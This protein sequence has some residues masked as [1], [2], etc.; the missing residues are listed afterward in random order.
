MMTNSKTTKT[1]KQPDYA[2]IILVAAA[3]IILSALMANQPFVHVFA[4]NDTQA[5]TTTSSFTS[6]EWQSSDISITLNCSDNVGCSETYYCIDDE[7][8]CVPDT[9]YSGTIIHQDEGN[10]YIRFYST[11]L[12]L[13]IEDTKSQVLKLDKSAPSITIS[14]PTEGQQISGTFFV[15]NGA[16][17]DGTAGVKEV[18]INIGTLQGT[19]TG[20]TNWQ[21]QWG[22]FPDGSYTIIA[23]AMDYAGN[24]QNTSVHVIVGNP[25]TA[26]VISLENPPMVRNGRIEVIL[27]TS[28]PIQTIPG[29]SPL[30]SYAFP[31][32]GSIQI[33]LDGASQTWR[34]YM[35][36]S[37]SDHDKIGTFAFSATDFSGTQGNT[38]T[39]GSFFVVDAVKPRKIENFNA[40]TDKNQATLTWFYEGEPLKEYNLYRA[41][42]SNV[43]YANYYKTIPSDSTE[44]GDDLGGKTY[45][46]KIA[47]VDLAGNIGPLSD[48][49]SVSPGAG[50]SSNQSQS[51]PPVQQPAPQSNPQPQ[52]LPIEVIRLIDTAVE[53]IKSQIG[54]IDIA[55]VI[56]ERTSA[57]ED[58][59][60]M[61][62]INNAKATLTEQIDQLNSLRSSGRSRSEIESE[63]QRVSIRA[64]AIVKELPKEVILDGEE[65]IIQETSIEDIE[66]ISDYIVP[67]DLETSER[68]KYIVQN[69]RLQNKLEI[70]VTVTYYKVNLFE[71]SKDITL[72]KK[73]INSV[74][75]SVNSYVKNSSII[76]VVPK[77]VAQ[78][79]NEISFLTQ[80][81]EVLEEDPI[82]RF[83]AG[84]NEIKYYVNKKVDKSEL[85]KTKTLVISNELPSGGFTNLITGFVVYGK[86]AIDAVANIKIIFGLVIL[87]LLVVFYFVY[88]RDSSTISVAR[89]TR[90]NAFGKRGSDSFGQNRLERNSNRYNNFSHQHNNSRNQKVKG[91]SRAFQF[92]NRAGSSDGTRYM[93]QRQA[94]GDALGAQ[95]EMERVRRTE[96]GNG[97]SYPQNRAFDRTFEKLNEYAVPLT[98]SQRKQ[99]NDLTFGASARHGAQSSGRE[100]DHFEDVIARANSYIDDGKFS[101]AS[102][103][104]SLLLEMHK[105][106]DP[107]TRK[108]YYSE[109]LHVYNKLNLYSKIKELSETERMNPGLNLRNLLEH[110][111]EMYT[112]IAK[113]ESKD[114]R[115][116]KFAREY[117]DGAISRLMR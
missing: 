39:Q 4:E 1:K 83:G 54:E 71:G 18:K 57:A 48:E 65:V 85:E 84:T 73:E 95:G 51:Q 116:L 61:L 41:V 5:P 77:T 89:E 56:L 69:Q 86:S 15:I 3:F 52:P 59:G 68:D 9:L 111:S 93:E 91:N 44:T 35:F 28:E 110:V 16:S 23:T 66:G 87:S 20:T 81:Y 104:Y 79:A 24:A 109:L 25:P 75:Q 17:S 82:I 117:Y 33:P 22:N 101:L 107:L 96:E 13:N 70:K 58:L 36:I 60:L 37:E 26:R 94:R 46:Y 64:R 67:L 102:K 72:V 98:I 78:S 53:S 114:T 49:L 97:R 63:I 2:K 112:E 42:R 8:L 99:I 14:Q 32:E 43:G 103:S 106:F 34:G 11:D 10:S 100:E 40:E 38:I 88:L 27:Q 113:G 115:L 31:G 74:D 7:N 80:N 50:S 21:Y 30:L 47:A 19:A 29:V 92:L 45:Y 108:E 6:Q 62:Q 105:M 12:A 55:K 76:E 90:E